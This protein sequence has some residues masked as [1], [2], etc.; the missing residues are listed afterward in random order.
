MGKIF[1]EDVKAT[2]IEKNDLDALNAIQE[3]ENVRVRVISPI[4][5]NGTRFE[6]GNIVTLPRLDAD[7]HIKIGN[8]V[9]V[10]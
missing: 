9:I 6:E 10:K 4:E 2:S 3:L 1:S 7:F 8:C 5:N